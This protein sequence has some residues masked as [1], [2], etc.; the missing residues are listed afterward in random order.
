MSIYDSDQDPCDHH[1]S[2][3]DAR[4]QSLY[5]LQSKTPYWINGQLILGEGARPFCQQIHMIGL[6]GRSKRE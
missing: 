6:I 5:S 3:L 4:R 2:W 1:P